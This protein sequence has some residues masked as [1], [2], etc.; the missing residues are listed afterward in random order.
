MARLKAEHDAVSPLDR[1]SGPPDL[2]QNIK[3]IIPTGPIEIKNLKKPEVKPVT[4]I[5]MPEIVIE[6]PVQKTKRP[7][8]DQRQLTPEQKKLRKETVAQPVDGVGCASSNKP[9]TKSDM[10]RYIGERTK[11]DLWR[12]AYSNQKSL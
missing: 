10:D 9:P 2:S 1:A 11:T 5:E 7:E 4:R 12:L 6:V 8:A 3:K